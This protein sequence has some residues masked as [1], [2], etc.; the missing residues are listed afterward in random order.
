LEIGTG[1]PLEDA[2]LSN[3]LASLLCELGEYEKAA[4]A[5][6]RANALA[7]RFGDSLLT[8]LDLPQSLREL[9]AQRFRPRD[10]KGANG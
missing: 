10:T 8:S 7:R 2:S 3:L 1:D 6:E 5:L 4:W 9:E